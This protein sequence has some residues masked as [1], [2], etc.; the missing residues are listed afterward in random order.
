MITSEFSELA[1]VVDRQKRHLRVVHAAFAVNTASLAATLGVD[2][3]FAKGCW[4][5]L[6]HST[7][8]GCWRQA[9]M[10]ENVTTA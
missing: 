2:P 4:H 6:G 1:V 8:A 5:A 9:K 3:T 7:A 10:E